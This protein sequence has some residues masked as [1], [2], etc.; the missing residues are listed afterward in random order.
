M[1]TEKKKSK[2]CDGYCKYLEHSNKYISLAK[3][4]CDN[5]TLQE[6]IEYSQN[7]LNKH[8]KRCPLN[9]V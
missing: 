3:E 5:Q 2:F 4:V 8:C 7:K 6:L 9:E 1:L